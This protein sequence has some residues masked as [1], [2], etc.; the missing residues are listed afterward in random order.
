MF[1]QRIQGLQRGE[2]RLAILAGMENRKQTT[3][4]F[5][6]P[7]RFFGRLRRGDLQTGA[8]PASMAP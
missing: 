5:R 4:L 7:A 1:L 8:I 3:A 6:E 2:P